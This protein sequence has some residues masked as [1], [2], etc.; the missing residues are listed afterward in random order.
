MLV[1]SPGGAVASKTVEYVA[2]PT[3][4]SQQIDHLKKKMKKSSKDL[5]FEEAARLRDELNMMKKVAEEAE[6]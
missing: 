4:L 2:N 6:G 1:E 5:E 3:K